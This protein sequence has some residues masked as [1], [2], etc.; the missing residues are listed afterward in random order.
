MAKKQQFTGELLHIGVIRM[1]VTG[2]GEMDLYLRS[3]DD[4]RNVQL[5]STTLQP[6]TNRE[7]TTLANFIEQRAQL[8]GKT[9]EIDETFNVSTIILY[10]IPVS[11]G[12]PQ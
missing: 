5:P 10:Y 2:S 1:R 8:E 11:S 12:Y 3:L 6:T 9:T 7:P 4:V